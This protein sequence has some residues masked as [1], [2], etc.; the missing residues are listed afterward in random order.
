MRIVGACAFEEGAVATEFRRPLEPRAFVVC[1]PVARFWVV[2]HE[3]AQAKV[4]DLGRRVALE[5]AV[6]FAQKD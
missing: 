3:A 1:V 6:V 2:G 4:A 5:H